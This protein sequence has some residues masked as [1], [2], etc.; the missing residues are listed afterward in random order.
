MVYSLGATELLC[1]YCV[2][3]LFVPVA[4]KGNITDPI[5]FCIFYVG[6]NVCQAN[7]KKIVSF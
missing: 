7:E 3:V 4:V 1:N 2:F 5:L 6:E